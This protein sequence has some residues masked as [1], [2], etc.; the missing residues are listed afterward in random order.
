MTRYALDDKNRLVIT[1]RGKG[2]IAAHGRFTIDDRN[3]LHFS[4]DGF[5]REEVFEGTWHLDGNHDLVLRL[6]KG[7][8]RDAAGTLTFKGTLISAQA[9]ALIFEIAS[10][11]SGGL[12]HVQLLK[13]SV[14]W[15]ADSANRL[16]FTARQSEN[17]VA[18]ESGWQLN[19]NQQIVYRYEKFD[20]VRKD[21]VEETLAFE[22]YW[23]LQD[24]RKLTYYLGCSSEAKFEFRAQVE[25]PTIYPQRGLIKYRL[26]AG[27]RQMRSTG[28]RILCF[29]GSW[30]I[31]RALRLNFSMDCGS[32]GTR[33]YEFSSD[34]IFSGRGTVTFALKD[35]GGR[36][37]GLEVIFTHR[38]IKLSDGQV[39]LRL[40]ALRG[41]YGAYAGLRVSF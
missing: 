35:T 4:A 14:V 17:S 36:P 37:L 29:Y 27:A 34:I 13:L 18:L 33:T 22:G 23:R 38:F 20:L 7:S 21:R 12:L 6:A 10:R 41:Q 15:F 11:D 1:P 28:E 26:G 9:D 2:S 16:C 19:D 8:S 39:Y 32:A 31:S 25:T 5:G 3:R 30:K 24:A 40:E